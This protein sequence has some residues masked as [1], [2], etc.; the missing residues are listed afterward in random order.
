[1]ISIMSSI[2]SENTS[3]PKGRKRWL[4]VKRK[5][6]QSRNES[7]YDRD[8]ETSI[9]KCSMLKY[10]IYIYEHNEKKKWKTF[11]NQVRLLEV[12]NIII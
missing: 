7:R 10:V 3:V 6:N 5:K 9:K 11:K 4:I 2:E 12:E 1:M 8:N